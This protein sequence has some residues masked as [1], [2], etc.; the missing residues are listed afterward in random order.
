MQGV[1]IIYDDIMDGSITRRGHDCWHRKDDVG[2]GA[3]NDAMMIEN[4]IYYLLKRYCGDKSYY[5]DLMELFHDVAFITCLGQHQDVK[6]TSLDLNL[7][8]MDRYKSIVTNKTA[9]YSFYLPVALAMHMAGYKDPEMFRQ[10]KTIL[11]EIGNFF[12]I[13]DDFIDCFGDPMITGKIGTDIQDG[14]CSWL[15]IL[16]LQRC[17]PEQKQIMRENYGQKGELKKRKK[18]NFKF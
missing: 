13:Q 12:Q 2:L 17:S 16:A 18:L 3:V 4:A 14:K 1:F 5:H 8:T 6:T 10:A 7:F 11:F 15:A 9:Y